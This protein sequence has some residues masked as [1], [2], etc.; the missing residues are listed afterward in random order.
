MPDII[1]YDT[2]PMDTSEGILFVFSFEE[3]PEMK[4]GQTPTNP[5]VDPV[6]GLIIGVPTVTVADRVVD[7]AGTIVPAG[8][9]VQV[10]IQ[11]N[12]PGTYPL[13]C[14]VTFSGSSL[15]RVVKGRVIVE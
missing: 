12:T 4:E 14:R 8:K 2:R 5:V 15:P 11:S 9:G 1:Q 3:F 7:P 6:A 13:E 10:T